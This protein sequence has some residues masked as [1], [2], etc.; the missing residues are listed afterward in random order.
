MEFTSDD[1]ILW[2]YRGRTLEQGV[3]A[4]CAACNNGWMSQ[5]EE[6]TALIMRPMLRGE[7]VGVKMGYVAQS[8][9][10]SWATKTALVFQQLYPSESRVPG[11]CYRDFHKKQQPS[12]N[13]LVVLGARH[14]AADHKGRANVLEYNG[15]FTGDDNAGIQHIH[16]AV[17]AVYLAVVMWVGIKRK[18]PVPL[19]LSDEVARRLNIIW[20]LSSPEVFWPTG[21]ISEVGGL[22]NVFYALRYA[23]DGG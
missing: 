4:F 20:P 8:N 9:V 23:F 19:R 5:L 7:R 11:S 14:I 13:T 10:A 22:Q 1:S 21:S 15:Q 18:V 2:E 6:K 12:S 3:K 16:F 17:G